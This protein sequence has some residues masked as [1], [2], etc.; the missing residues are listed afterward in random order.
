MKRDFCAKGLFQAV[1]Y[2]FHKYGKHSPSS[3][4]SWLFLRDRVMTQSFSTKHLCQFDW[5]AAPN[6]RRAEDSSKQR[7][8]ERRLRCHPA[9]SINPRSSY[10]SL[11]RLFKCQTIKPVFALLKGGAST[12]QSGPFVDLRL[13]CSLTLPPALLL[14]MGSE[15][16]TT[17][18]VPTCW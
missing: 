11:N 18:W 17:A 6:T 13:L 15:P 14:E 2:I 8:P 12:L 16:I 3:Q 1:I 4:G 5:N 10:V 7:H 9:F